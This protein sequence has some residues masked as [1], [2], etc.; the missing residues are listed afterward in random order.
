MISDS[1]LIFEASNAMD[2]S[3]IVKVKDIQESSDGIIPEKVEFSDMVSIDIT[4]EKSGGVLKRIVKEGEGEEFPG[5]GDRVSVHYTGWRLG[6]EPIE[7]DSSRKGDRFEFNLGRGTVIKGWD[8]GLSTMKKGEVAVFICHPKYAYGDLGYPPA[9]PPFTPLIFEIELFHWKLEDLSPK[10]DDSILRKVL[11]R[12]ES[13]IYPN[14]GSQVKVHIVRYMENN[15][16][17]VVE[18]DFTL[19]E[20]CIA[21]VPEGI[22][23]ALLKFHLKEKS[24]IY[25]RSKYAEDTDEASDAEVKYEITLTDFKKAKEVWEMNSDEKFEKAKLS[26]EKGINFFKMGHYKMALKSFKWIITCLENEPGVSPETR[27]S[28]RLLLLSGYLNVALCHQKMENHLDVIKVCNK[29]LAIDPN[30]EKA[31]FRRGQAKEQI[32]DCEEALSDFQTLCT[33]NPDNKAARNYTVVCRNK[34]K[35]QL[36]KDKS[37]YNKMFELFVKQDE[38][39]LKNM[40]T[41]TGVWEGS[42]DEE[43]TN[44]T[45]GTRQSLLGDSN[46][47]LLE[48]NV[49]ELSNTAHG[50]I[51]YKM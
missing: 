11:E 42:R 39:R 23:L 32:N 37:T 16:V 2:D 36:Q 7:F 34:M 49:I 19:G 10:K 51:S 6:K 29:A 45:M 44:E 18:K 3:E 27:E 9:I 15:P 5:Y 38:E 33:L 17:E 4:P 40:K 48:A 21:G 41:E 28:R 1:D 22:E 20:G 8:L 43:S 25:L 31:L 30:N 24:L 13:A 35:K 12:G 46:S 14:E 26:K 50:T 47:A